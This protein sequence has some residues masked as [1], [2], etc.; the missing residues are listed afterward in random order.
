MIQTVEKRLLKYVPKSSIPF[1]V[2]LD[3]EHQVDGTNTYFLTFADEQL[4]E[5]SCVCDSVS[6]LRFNAKYYWTLFQ[7][8]VR[9]E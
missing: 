5:L 2:W 8:G 3:H 4:N 1:I 6:E 9:D 7:N